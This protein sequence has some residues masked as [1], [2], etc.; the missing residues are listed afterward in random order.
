[1]AKRGRE[2]IRLIVGVAESVL[3]YFSAINAQRLHLGLLYH[4]VDD[5]G[6]RRLDGALIAIRRKK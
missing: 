1:M 4:H 3:P 6:K 2:T 5:A